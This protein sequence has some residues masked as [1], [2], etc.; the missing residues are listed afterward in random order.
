[1]QVL[2]GGSL[3]KPFVQFFAGIGDVVISGLQ[4]FMMGTSS[5]WSV[6]L[7]VDHAYV[8][9]LEKK[10]DESGPEITT[11]TINGKKLNKGWVTWDGE[12]D[13]ITVPNVLYAPEMIFSNKVPGLDI[14]FIQEPD[15]NKYQ[16]VEEGM[17]AKTS[18]SSVLHSV[19][20]TW[21]MAFRNIAIV[22]L[23]SILVYIAIRII[24]S[25]NGEEKAKYKQRIMDWLVALC[26]L[27]VLHYMMSFIITITEEVTKVFEKA[28][29]INVEVANGSQPIEGTDDRDNVDFKFQTTLMGY[30][31]FMVQMED[32]FEM[33][34]Y[35][36]LYL[37]L[38]VYTIMFTVMYLKRVLYI[39][40][41]TMIAPLVALTYPLDKISDG[42]AQ[43][44]DMWM[45]EYIFNAIM[46]P[47]HLALYTMLIGAS[48]QLAT[49]NPI[50]ALVAMGFI[51]PADKFIRKMF[52]FE[53]AQTAGQ[54]KGFATGALTM[55]A[56]N[57]LTS[58]GKKGNSEGDGSGDS[59]GSSGNGQ[60]RTS[61]GN[62]DMDVI[63]SG[64]GNS[65]GDDEPERDEDHQRLLDDRAEYQRMVDDENASDLD[66]EE[67]QANIGYI[68]DDMEARG[69][70][71][72][73]REEIGQGTGARETTTVGGTAG[74]FG[75]GMAAVARKKGRTLKR[76]LS[77]MPG[78]VGKGAIRYTGKVAG[79]GVRA[80]G[81][82]AL[83]A[84]P[85]AVSAVTSGDPMGEIK[86]MGA[87]MASGAAG[88][89][90]SGGQKAESI[91]QG[92]IDD[93]KTYDNATTTYEERKK[94]EVNKK[95]SQM[96][97]DEQTISDIRNKLQKSG[98]ND[99]PEKWL[100]D[101][102]GTIKGYYENGVKDINTIYNVEEL[103][104]QHGFSDEY[105]HEVAKE[106]DRLGDKTNDK[107]YMQDYKKDLVDNGATRNDSNRF[108]R[109]LT[110]AR[111]D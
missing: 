10:V 49:E 23:L 79:A 97:Q 21:Y 48:M 108:A 15:A 18:S 95:Y 36:V 64:G 84:I 81:M 107:T 104:D 35:T 51:I 29:V 5:L 8:E 62:P 26:L 57:K 61:G 69:Y 6:E 3:F 46:Q 2:L 83:A 75:A 7:P 52:G 45:K 19:V 16:S 86:T 92:V 13:D 101:N 4:Y 78:N 58:G 47:M 85:L 82:G 50:Y 99:K 98:R 71:T 20:S 88:G 109:M 73:E 77:N 11:I 59:G 17:P 28:Q 67:A 31:K 12:Y 34:V 91:R 44:F 96:A 102:E 94:K 22:G 27:F 103:K 72:N 30:I 42:K 25:S 56:L 74:G 106:A 111:K 53:K 89:W 14:N 38:V 65:N 90:K 63:S 70:N 76:N 24:I 41:L 39:A 110:A 87:I 54:S 43:A 105:G 100:K 93:K 33:A 9:Y 66:R 80:L 1:M 55:S 60:V 32:I 68:D 40:F 37:S